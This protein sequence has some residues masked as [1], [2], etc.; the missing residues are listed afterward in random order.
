MKI[1]QINNPTRTEKRYVAN[2]MGHSLDVSDSIY[3]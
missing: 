2:H 1:F 3:K